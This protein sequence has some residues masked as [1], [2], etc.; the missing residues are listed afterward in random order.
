MT[1]SD[2]GVLKNDP[3]ANCAYVFLNFF[4][5]FYDRNFVKRISTSEC[6]QEDIHFFSRDIK[7]LNYHKKYLIYFL[8][9]VSII[10]GLFCKP[11][12][13]HITLISHG[14]LGAMCKLP[15]PA[16]IMTMKNIR[17]EFLIFY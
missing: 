2:G 5:F 4:F 1:N 3:Q 6:K 14:S 13:L 16:K 17:K 10:S 9:R 15:R 7:S 11:G 12:L 8:M